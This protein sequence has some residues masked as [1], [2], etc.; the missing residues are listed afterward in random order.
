MTHLDLKNYIVNF[1][2]RRLRR[3]YHNYIFLPF[4]IKRCKISLQMCAASLHRENPLGEEKRHFSLF[5]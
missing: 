1:Q 4:F 2:Q 3:F 5:S